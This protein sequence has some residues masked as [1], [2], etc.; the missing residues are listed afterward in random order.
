VVSGK[1]KGRVGLLGVVSSCGEPIKLAGASGK[2]EPKGFDGEP[3]GER[4]TL[5]SVSSQVWCEGE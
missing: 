2:G 4:A 3:E 1:E 5:F